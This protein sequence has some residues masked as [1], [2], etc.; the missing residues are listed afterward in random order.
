M[1]EFLPFFAAVAILT[2]WF[3]VS[4][5]RSKK[6]VTKLVEYFQGH[7]SKPIGDAIFNYRGYEFRIVRIARG[8]GQTGV[9]G[10]YPV[11][12]TYLSAN[13]ESTVNAASKVLVG[14]AESGQYTRGRFLILPPHFTE[15]IAGKKYL[16]GSSDERALELFKRQK[17][18][19]SLEPVVSCLFKEKFN[20]LSIGPELH[21]SGMGIRK[22]RVLSYVGLP[23]EIY[24]NPEMI[25]PYLNSLIDFCAFL[26]VSPESRDGSR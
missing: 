2:T 4:Y 10:S 8:G 25:V 13:S 15:D 6:R 14:H 23:E 11:L 17:M 7:C 9:G 3:F 26:N 21:V 18:E 20:H 12:T 1:L 19:P 16:F 22:K 24:T 5:S